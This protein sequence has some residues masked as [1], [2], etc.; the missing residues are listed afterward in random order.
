[1]GLSF[2][3]DLSPCICQTKPM[4][5]N[6]CSSGLN[7]GFFVAFHYI[8][9]TFLIDVW[10]LGKKVPFSYMTFLQYNVKLLSSSSKHQHWVKL[11]VLK[12]IPS[13]IFGS[14]P[15]VENHCFKPQL[16]TTLCCAYTWC[17]DT[18]YI[19]IRDS[20]TRHRRFTKGL[21][22]TVLGP[23]LQTIVIF[24]LQNRNSVHAM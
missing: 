6:C 11:N 2:N 18:I 7:L 8:T 14:W 1:M 15:S 20:L 19:Y 22:F 16:K 10:E 4:V 9:I 21:M 23:Q 24:L 5:L 17:L 3:S 13:P 12:F